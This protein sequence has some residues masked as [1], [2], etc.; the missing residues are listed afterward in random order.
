MRRFLAAALLLSAARGRALEVDERLT[1]RFLRLSSTKKTVLVNRGIE[2]GLVAGDHA[3]FFTT[4]GVVARG[5]VAQVSPTRSV[6]SLYRIVDADAVAADGL[7]DIKITPPVKLTGDPSRSLFQD[8]EVAAPAPVPEGV[9]LAP[10]A[11]DLGDTDLE[12]DIREEIAD[13]DP[14]VVVSREARDE[15]VVGDRDMELLARFHMDMSTASFDLGAGGTEEVE[16]TEGGTAFSLG[17]E[18]YFAGRG[19]LLGALSLWGTLHRGASDSVLASGWESSTSVMEYG[20]GASYHFLASPLSE[21]RVIGFVGAGG[22]MGSTTDVITDPG[23]AGGAR[24]SSSSALARIAGVENAGSST[25]LSL[26]A[27]LKYYAA[28]GWGGRAEVDFYRRSESYAF[29]DATMNY[30]RS[31][32]GPRVRLGVAYRW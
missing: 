23:A 22:G 7:A 5:V 21:G 12:A 1:V 2:D 13:L 18:K 27:G 26:V 8:D 6:W 11:D 31:V 15:G 30:E 28:G 9:A 14:D 20:G 10:G 25:F 32:G 17:V 3:R 19:G 16:E 29:T 4:S 24:A